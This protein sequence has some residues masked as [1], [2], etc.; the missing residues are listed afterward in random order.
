MLISIY[1]FLFVYAIDDKANDYLGKSRTLFTLLFDA[2]PE[3][4]PT[5][6]ADTCAEFKYGL[7]SHTQ[8]LNRLLGANGLELSEHFVPM[9]GDC[10]FIASEREHTSNAVMIFAYTFILSLNF[11]NPH[12]TGIRW[13]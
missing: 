7:E 4:W 3:L 11:K 5:F 9:E 8:S 1:T 2:T 12:T 10:M 6:N 13:Q